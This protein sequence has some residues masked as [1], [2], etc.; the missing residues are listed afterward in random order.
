M[1]KQDLAKGNT[2]EEFKDLNNFSLT[3]EA[4]QRENRSNLLFK[5]IF[6]RVEFLREFAGQHVR[7]E[8]LE[9]LLLLISARL[10]K[11]DLTPEQYTQMLDVIEAYM[12]RRYLCGE[13]I[14]SRRMKSFLDE[15]VTNNKQCT[16][17]EL[18]QFLANSKTDRW[19]TDDDVKAALPEIGDRKRSKGLQLVF[20][21]IENHKRC[22]EHARWGKVGTGVRSTE[23]GIPEMVD[24]KLTREHVTPQASGK[25]GP[26]VSGT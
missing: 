5:Q 12:V 17:E 7:W 3:W 15:V 24:L 2:E 1:Y 8:Q 21:R 11:G 16:P 18:Q 22:N 23:I 10:I 13:G 6:D 26:T 25:R 14:V 4:M 19:P 20:Y 9:S